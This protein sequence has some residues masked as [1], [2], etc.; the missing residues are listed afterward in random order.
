MS[1]DI[2]C[3]QCEHLEKCGG[4]MEEEATRT[5]QCGDSCGHYDNLNRCCWQATEKSLCFHV[6][7]GDYCHLNY[8]ETDFQ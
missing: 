4:K 7:E 1:C 6:S 2:P 8:K 3:D 5:R